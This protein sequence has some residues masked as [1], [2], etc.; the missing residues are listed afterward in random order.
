MTGLYYIAAFIAVI[1]LLT[2]VHEYGHFLAARLWPF[3]R[4][5]ARLFLPARLAASAGGAMTPGES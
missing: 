2:T 5:R 3:P 4:R 1:V